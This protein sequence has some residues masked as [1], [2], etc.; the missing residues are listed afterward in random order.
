MAGARPIRSVYC[1]VT[2]RAVPA[3]VGRGIPL[4]FSSQTQASVSCVRTTQTAPHVPRYETL[5]SLSC[6]L[7]Y[8]RR[9]LLDLLVPGSA[10]QSGI[11]TSGKLM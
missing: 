7:M 1:A 9:R 3:S 4:G 8:I 11:E 6:T 2:S 5:N 10:D